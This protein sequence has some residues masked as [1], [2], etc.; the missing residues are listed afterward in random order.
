MKVESLHALFMEGLQDIYDAEKQV[1]KALPLM[2]KAAQA[3]DLRR[4]FE[5]HLTQT[6]GHIDRLEQIF[7]LMGE[8]AKGVQ[9][10]RR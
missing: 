8:P 7:Q 5:E 3:P 10:T 2:A 6:E 1:T 4:A 9:V